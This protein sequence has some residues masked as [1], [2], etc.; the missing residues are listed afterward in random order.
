MNHFSVQ[1][2]GDVIVDAA[3]WVEHLSD[4]S[5]TFLGAMEPRSTT[6]IDAFEHHLGLDVRL[7]YSYD[8]E[9]IGE[10]L[11]HPQPAITMQ[12]VLDPS[13]LMQM[14]YVLDFTRLSSY[15]QYHRW[16]Q[17]YTQWDGQIGHRLRVTIHTL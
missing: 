7:M 16:N 13:G 1:D 2:N 6:V 9:R 15:A 5:V 10:S 17:V 12:R 3:V 14:R 4:L 11:D 8:D